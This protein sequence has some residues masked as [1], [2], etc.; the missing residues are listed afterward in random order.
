MAK[1]GR[2]PNEPGCRSIRNGSEKSIS[3]FLSGLLPLFWR[4]CFF[5]P[6]V[7]THNDFAAGNGPISDDFHGRH[8]NASGVPPPAHKS[9]FTELYQLKHWAGV[10]VFGKTLHFQL[11]CGQPGVSFPDDLV[12]GRPAT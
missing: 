1:Q 6:T 9:F 11:C 12:A 4:K 2:S 8:R 10:S 5:P 7:E 3:F